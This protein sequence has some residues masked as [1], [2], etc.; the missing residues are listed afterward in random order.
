MNL[1]N[2]EAL[3]SLY[4]HEDRACVDDSTA[5]RPL[6][7]AEMAAI[8][9]LESNFERRRTGLESEITVGWV[10]KQGNNIPHK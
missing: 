4:R 8:D 7:R 10:R 3:G 9:R 6:P 2:R 1:G 5:R